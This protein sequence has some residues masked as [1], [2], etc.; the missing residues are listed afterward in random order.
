MAR[1]H[2]W[3][4]FSDDTPVID[5]DFAPLIDF[6]LARK[7]EVMIYSFARGQFSFLFGFFA[8]IIEFFV[9]FIFAS[10][11]VNNFKVNISLKSKKVKES[12]NDFCIML[13][14]WVGT[15]LRGV[16]QQMTLEYVRFTHDSI[17]TYTH[18]L[19]GDIHNGSF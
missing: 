4:A 1:C 17:L 6:D 3:R 15:N 14:Y 18:I 10:L 11:E 5:F 8:F 16:S 12:R 9:S 19:K 13:L 7:V 2:P